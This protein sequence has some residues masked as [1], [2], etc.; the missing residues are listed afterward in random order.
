VRLFSLVGIIGVIIH[1][2][3][4]GGLAL[5]KTGFL[6]VLSLLALVLV[7]STPL[8][9]QLLISLLAVFTVASLRSVFG[10]NRTLYMGV[11]VFATAFAILMAAIL[12]P[13]Y[14]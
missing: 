2:K 1:D 8:T 7:P 4:K 3:G 9:L 14:A 5:L 13:D 12:I 10:Y 6:S 11:I